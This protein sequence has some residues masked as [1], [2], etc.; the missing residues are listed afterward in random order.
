MLL[1]HLNYDF[2]ISAFTKT[3]LSINYDVAHFAGSECTSLS[4]DNMKGRGVALHVKKDLD[5][6][7]SHRK[8]G[9]YYTRHCVYTSSG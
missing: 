8:V 1:D 4:P 3:W 9:R 6:H 2:N 5:V 7:V